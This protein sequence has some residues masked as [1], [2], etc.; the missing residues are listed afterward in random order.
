MSNSVQNVFLLVHNKPQPK[1]AHKNSL[2]RGKAETNLILFLSPLP[3][4]VL[5]EKGKEGVVTLSSSHLS[6][7]NGKPDNNCSAFNLMHNS[8]IHPESQWYCLDKYPQLSVLQ[9]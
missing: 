6:L 2:A 5:D 4:K 8:D 7:R 9:G 3:T 1:P